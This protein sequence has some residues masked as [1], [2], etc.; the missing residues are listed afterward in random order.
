MSLPPGTRLGTY[1]VIEPVGSGGMG[2]VYR[3][4]DSRLR[5]D[6]ALK[7]LPD[8]RQFDPE[9]RARFEREALALAALNHPNIATVHGVENVDGIQALVMELVEGDTLADRLAAEAL[10]SP[11]SSP[12]RSRS[13]AVR[14]PGLLPLDQAL[15]IARQIADALEAAHE[16]GIVHRDLK[17]SN[18]K[19]RPDGTVKVLDFG[20][21]K[22][23]A[24][25]GP[26]NV[27]AATLTSDCAVVGTPA[28]MSPEQ[29]RGQ[30]LDRRT[31]IW[32]FGCVLYELLTGRRAFPGS[33]AAD[34][35]SGVLEREPDYDALPAR[36][37]PQVRRLLVHC[38]EKDPR[39]RLR[40]IGDARIELDEAATV[41]RLADPRRLPDPADRPPPARSIPLRV[42]LLVMAVVVGGS[43]AYYGRLVRQATATEPSGPRETVRLTFDDGLQTDPSFSPDGRS[44]AYASDKSGN[45]DIWTQ[46]LSG[47]NP[48]RVTSHPAQEWQPQWSPAGDNIV[49]RSER[50]SGGL[51][52]VPATGGF[53]RKI[54]D[55]GYRPLWSPAGSHVL[56]TG[57]HTPGIN[58]PLYVVGLDG[59]P[60]RPV[61]RGA[62]PL[63]GAFGWY[64]DEKAVLLLRA[65]APT[66]VVDLRSVTVAD[67]RA[68]PWTVADE[69][70][71]RFVDL[72][73]TIRHAEAITW[74]SA[75]ATIIFA[76]VARGSSGIW[77]LHVD[78]GAA[79]VIGGPDRL[80]EMTEA[81]GVSLTADK[82]RAAFVVASMTAR[83]WSYPL[84]D[85]TVR[86]DQGQPITGAAVSSS[87]PDL[88]MDGSQ[89]LYVL[90]RPASR[91]REELIVRSMADGRERTV[92]VIDG[93]REALALARWTHD[94]RRISYAYLE[95]A[96]PATSAR[97]LDVASGHE[98]QFTSHLPVDRRQV[99]WAH[100]QLNS[101]S[102]DDQLVASS[103]RQYVPEQVAIALLPASGA[104]HADRAARIVTS[105][106]S[107]V[108]QPVISPNG[109]WVAFRGTTSARDSPATGA[110]SIMV[111][112][113]DG[114]PPSAW[115]RMGADGQVWDDKPRWSHDGRRLYFTSTRGGPLN[116]W[117]RDFDPEKGVAIGAPFQV[118]RFAGPG[119][120]IQSDL[121][122]MELAVSR[123]RMIVPIVHP[124][125]GIWMVDIAN[126]PK[127]TPGR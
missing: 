114:G 41:L 44:I 1:E 122:T 112:G 85:R 5:R 15:T 68:T 62:P 76:G 21:A 8:H 14:D 43:L 66:F 56:F 24:D 77:K 29:A 16:R 67:G 63:L 38:L 49:F 81:V 4:R 94:G 80:S 33:T 87:G 101:W 46:P 36:T 61:F 37:P 73:L 84:I 35:I 115:R 119:E 126:S 22:A 28:Y 6:V 72:E 65:Y 18:I 45:F 48:V 96:G 98:F 116:V 123:D 88:T 93:S 27:T 3:A 60:P 117:A 40:D 79:R 78:P 75:D 10:H 71:R 13:G 100:H 111:I 113:I 32:A 125:G 92:R 102:A 69:V 52:V 26:A 118:T 57:V 89:L 70:A 82:T 106:P 86:L 103:G 34:T 109:R 47:G 11:G 90:S 107:W 51:F 39:R 50:D 2:A 9:A 83:L 104:P 17:P 54:A 74:S 120:Q 58:A 97:L 124:Q 23:L 105:S 19:I 64:G 42:G 53:E 121:R 127:A 108:G 59:R 110:S 12:V 20:L 7:V 30:D 55:F 25:E 99:A 31:D 91:Q 95:L